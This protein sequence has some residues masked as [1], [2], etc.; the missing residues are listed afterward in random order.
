M[1]CLETRLAAFVAASGLPVFSSCELLR[2]LSRLPT[3]EV[4]LLSHK[5]EE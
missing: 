2:V 1:T 3:L 5:N 4:T